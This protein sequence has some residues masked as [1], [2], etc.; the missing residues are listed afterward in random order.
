MPTHPHRPTG[1]RPT[2]TAWLATTAVLLLATAGG[3]CAS[4]VRDAAATA[5]P[6]VVHAGLHEANEPDE[7]KQ[8]SRLADSEGLR[9][10]GRSIG[11]GVGIGL[12]NQANQL[13]GVTPDAKPTPGGA[14]RPAASGPAGGPAGKVPT[15]ATPG[16]AAVSAIAG[17]GGLNGF[18]HSSIQEAF[19][20][21]TDPQFQ[22]GERALAESIGEGAVDGMITVLNK[23]GGDIGDT[24]RKQL[25]PIVQELIREQIAPAVLEM[26]RSGAIDTLKLSVRPDLQ[27]DVVRNA[28]NASL[29]ASRGTH[30]ALVQSGVLA[31]DGDLAPHLRL[32]IWVVAAAAGVLFLAM[33][34]L[35]VMLNLLALH[36]WRQRRGQRPRPE[37]APTT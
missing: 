11:E 34:S 6:V 33:L 27:P 13:A 32:Y 2:S 22:A 23:R 26:V 9:H 20:A 10:V 5:T 25:G 18:V 37:A 15:A 7:Q 12:F 8:I 3:G 24:V 1:P 31:P 36:N 29:G 21:A 16:A 14:T 17:G 19:L 28:Q 30:E 4:A 35:L